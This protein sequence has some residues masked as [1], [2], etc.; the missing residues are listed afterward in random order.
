MWLK[1]FAHNSEI[2]Q[3]LNFNWTS[4]LRNNYLGNNNF[5]NN[6]SGEVKKVGN[7]G[8]LNKLF[9]IYKLLKFFWV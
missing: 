2:S 8:K 5:L 3:A 9:L 7:G 4:L 6:F 1:I